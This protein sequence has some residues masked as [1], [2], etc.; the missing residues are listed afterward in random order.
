MQS[1]EV[2]NSPHGRSRPKIKTNVVSLVILVGIQKQ[3]IHTVPACLS[4]SS[5]SFGVV[6]RRALMTSGSMDSKTGALRSV[7]GEDH[8]STEADRHCEANRDKMG[9]AMNGFILIVKS[10]KD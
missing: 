9:K 1:T 4:P 3:F 2:P 5:F 8:M 6:P 7:R 10:D